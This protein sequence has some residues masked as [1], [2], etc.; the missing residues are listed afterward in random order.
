MDTDPKK[1]ILA[2]HAQG[3]S[4]KE[5]RQITGLTMKDIEAIITPQQVEKT[6]ASPNMAKPAN[7]K[8]GTEQVK[9]NPYQYSPNYAQAQ[10]N[11]TQAIYNYIQST[12]GTQPKESRPKPKAL[13]ADYDDYN[14]RGEA[15]ERLEKS[16]RAS[17][18]KDTIKKMPKRAGKWVIG[19]ARQEMYNTADYALQEGFGQFGRY[20]SKKVGF[21]AKAARFDLE[22]EIS[23]SNL[24]DDLKDRLR[25]LLIKGGDQGHEE[26]VNTLKGGALAPPS[27]PKNIDENFVEKIDETT[28]KI[29]RKLDE[30]IKIIRDMTSGG[31]GPM[32][33]DITQTGRS[34]LGV[35]GL[36]G[37]GGLAG[38]A[39]LAWSMSGNKA[40]AAVPVDT[41]LAQNEQT[42]DATRRRTEQQQNQMQPGKPIQTLTYKADEI[43]FDADDI[44]FENKGG[45]TNNNDALTPPSGGGGGP[46][47][48]TTPSGGVPTGLRAEGERKR[49][50]ERHGSGGASL[51]APERGMGDPSKPN[52]LTPPPG[53]QG[54][55]SGASPYGTLQPP[56]NP[57]VTDLPQFPEQPGK[58][59][60]GM[61]DPKPGATPPNNN[62]KAGDQPP[63]MRL[64]PET[65][66]PLPGTLTP[67]PS[68][69]VPEK[70]DHTNSQ[71]LVRNFIQSNSI[72]RL[73]KGNGVS[74]EP[75]RNDRDLM[76]E[77]T[78]LQAEEM[79]GGLKSAASALPSMD[80]KMKGEDSWTGSESIVPTR[81]RDH[82]D[83][84]FPGLGDE[85][86]TPYHRLGL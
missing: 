4:P 86:K 70:K 56:Q 83:S 41:S 11:Q 59:G 53:W 73:A 30:T 69:M 37:L 51:T 38:L 12:K 42:E 80:K 24:G 82:F 84:G 1:L 78:N 15:M 8:V 48:S 7:I 71:D 81:R 10:Y 5:I 55:K 52:G 47:A 31:T 39:G 57:K 21:H 2:L 68:T 20:I 65:T 16:D 66:P 67:R 35:K 18:L 34:S 29:T 79:F 64:N 75:R 54:G 26:V 46:D 40:D 6:P 43:V 36:A 23:K 76:T 25:D 33:E 62:P 22:R 44:V 3:V 60:G 17:R 63:L 58:S 13:A 9:S 45:D 27:S 72:D 85:L 50:Q 74:F 19:K 49:Q 28:L 61:F 14:H 77:S 32:N